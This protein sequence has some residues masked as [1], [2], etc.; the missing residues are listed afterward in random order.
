MITKNISEIEKELQQLVKKIAIPDSKYEEAKKNY[1]AVGDWLSNET[2]ELNEY[3]PQIYPQGSFALGTAIMPLNGCEHDIDA[4]CLLQLSK[5]NIT[6]KQLKELVGKRLKEHKVYE[7]MLEPKE[8]GRRCWTLKYADY[9][10]FH[11]D[12]LPA[13]P[14]NTVFFNNSIYK[15]EIEKYAI[16]ITDKTKDDYAFLSSNWLKSNPQGYVNWFLQEMKNKTNSGRLQNLAC[17]ESVEELPLYRQKH[18]LQQAIQ[19]LKR[20]RDIKFGTDE[21]KPISIIITTLATKAYLGENTLYET[22]QN[23]CRTMGQ[24]IENRDGIYWVENPVNP[25]ENFADKWQETPQKAESF[26]KWLKSLNELFDDLLDENVNLSEILDNAYGCKQTDFN[27]SAIITKTQYMSNPIVSFNLPYRQT[28]PWIMQKRNNV[29]ISATFKQ[30]NRVKKYENNGTP[31]P[32]HG[33]IQFTAKTDALEP[34]TVKWQILNTGEEAKAAGIQ[35]LRGD[36]YSSESGEKNIRR[37]NT[38]YKGHH[39]AQAYIIKDGICIGKSDE[40]I[41][42]IS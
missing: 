12:I 38:L 1:E 39:M 32:K 16:Y 26:F 36:F 33:T 6:Q 20:H 8:G 30:N 24:F 21:N 37:E 17:N 27:K 9:R 10:N 2:S 34:Y 41:V 18:V 4:V 15:N 23:I 14:C 29:K 35:Q 28:P 7:A 31:L 13:I 5:E 42:N 19:L 40:F 11:I 3:N 25:R 22:L